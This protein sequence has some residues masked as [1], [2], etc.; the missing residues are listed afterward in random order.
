MSH[1]D[2]TTVILD[3]VLLEVKLFSC[4]SYASK[5]ICGIHLDDNNDKDE[6][7]KKDDYDGLSS[8]DVFLSL[9][10]FFLPFKKGRSVFPSRFEML[11]PYKSKSYVFVEYK[12]HDILRKK[13][14]H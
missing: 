13:E 11:F 14:K 7:E 1:N 2:T 6:I 9:G 3:V 8:F 4:S 12:R 10:S 5:S